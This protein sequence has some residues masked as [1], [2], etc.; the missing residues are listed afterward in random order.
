MACPAV[1]LDAMEAAAA[2]FPSLAKP[3]QKYLR[4]TRQQ[5]WHTA[6]SVLNHLSTCLR[7]GLAPRAFLDRYL[8]YQPVLQGNREG[9]VVSWALVS[10]ISVSRTISNDLNFLLRNGDLSLFVTVAALPHINLTEQVVD[11]KNNKFTLRLN[12]ETSV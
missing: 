1:P 3:L 11:P 4:A 8:S 7:L 2:V 12:S 10:D 5:P 6:E 9:N